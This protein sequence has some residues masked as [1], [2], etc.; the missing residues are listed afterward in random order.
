MGSGRYRN[1][2][3]V[4]RF[5]NSFSYLLVVEFLLIQIIMGSGRYRNPS[6]VVRFVNSS[7]VLSLIRTRMGP[8]EVV[9][10][11]LLWL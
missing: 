2:S 7:V 6:G 4:V 3:G 1:P 8:G 11:L 10:E 9:T 5:V